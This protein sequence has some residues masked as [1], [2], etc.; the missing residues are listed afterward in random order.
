M[1]LE[2]VTENGTYWGIIVEPRVEFVPP[3]EVVQLVGVSQLRRLGV[4]L[5]G[6]LREGRG[7]D[8]S[9]SFPDNQIG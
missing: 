4:R 6:R 3:G 2:D 1:K 9:A 8:S 7:G 5:L